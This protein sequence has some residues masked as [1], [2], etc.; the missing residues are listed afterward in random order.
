MKSSART[1]SAELPDSGQLALVTHTPSLHE[2][3]R[4]DI[5][6]YFHDTFSLY[7]SLFECLSGD[8]AFY[9]R[10]NTLRHPLIFYYGHTAV[11]FINKMNVAGLINERVFPKI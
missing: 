7:E 10:A 2:A 8:E 5:R 6:R 3:T 9:A 11:F 4:E 1:Y